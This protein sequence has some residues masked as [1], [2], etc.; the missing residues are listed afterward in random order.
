MKKYANDVIKLK[1]EGKNKLERI[2]DLVYLG[3]WVSYYLAIMNKINPTPVEAID[4]LKNKLAE[5]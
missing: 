3:D 5:N 4:F 2:F 1:G